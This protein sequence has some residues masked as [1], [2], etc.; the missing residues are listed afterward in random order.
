VPRGLKI[1]GKAMSTTLT[2]PQNTT[3]A[4]ERRLRARVLSGSAIM[5]VGSVFVGGMNLIY[6]FA[7]AHKLG[8]SQFGHAS[9]TYTIL[10][11]LSAVT[12][13]FQ[14]VC[15]K[16]VARSNSKIEQTAIYRHLH[17]RSWMYSASIGLCLT[18]LSPEIS[19]YLNLPT[20]LFV[21]IIAI[22]IVFYI[23]LGVR[24]GL[25]QGQCDFQALAVNLS[26]EVL[27]KLVG[28]VVLMSAGYGV[29]GVVGAMSASLIVA[30]FVAAPRKHHI[31]IDP[32]AKPILKTSLD[33]GIQA[34]IFFVGQVIIN[35]LD[36]LL[37]KHFFSATEAGTYAA[38]ALLGRLVY[39]LSWSVVSS[40][41]PL[42][43]RARSDEA[44]GRAVL[45]TALSLVLL[46]AV[47]FT[48]GA[49]LAP[50]SLWHVLLG[51]GFPA[52]GRGF[53]SSLLVLY[54]VTTAVYS[55]AVVL[56]TYEISRKIGNVSWLQLIFSGAIISGIYLFH[57]TLPQVIVVQLILMMFLLLIVAVPFARAGALNETPGEQTGLKR[58][59][60]IGEDEVIA[61][62]LRGEFLQHHEF[63]GYR[64]P[65]AK[66]V[67]Q[68]DLKNAQ[69]N[70]YRRALLDRRRGRLWRE[71]P[72]DTEWWEVE[73]SPQDIR[74]TRV[75][76]RNQWLRY[77]GRGF[78]L[79]DVAA[80]IRSHMLTNSQ[81]RFITK[82]KSLSIEVSE[83]VQFPSVI[84][85]AID[86]D[87][88]LT[89]IEGNHR[90]AAAALVSPE[91]A[92]K[93]F[94]F[95]C[96]FSSRMEE[97]CWYQTNPSTL[98]RYARNGFSYHFKHRKMMEAILKQVKIAP[99]A[100]K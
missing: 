74:R 29:A 11:L 47:V 49:W 8:A 77:G 1:S 6:N 27:I 30:Y 18:L 57:R 80:R 22:G 60:K 19:R 51:A 53:Y 48:L 79:L 65:F 32:T 40:M 16:F 50:T 59:R 26:L 82:L 31:S 97:C 91:T 95:F 3:H 75:F 5:L 2:N 13:S 96:G 10:M 44:G 70:D 67:A 20:N 34:L 37:V 43:A 78:W 84:L 81:D 93:R 41:F 45:S 76:A 71:L 4:A 99:I 23:P 7:I 92:H 94:R 21:R 25:L 56:M 52:V 66:L 63:L 42:S 36:I 98:F 89:I 28:A 39:I 85:I 38:V 83:N 90:M 24:R 12:L 9:V 58:I 72:N 14:L 88:A 100:P 73:L 64:E 86:D 62:F 33:E 17:R 54:I 68:P 46:I 87:S 15:S 61:E 35:N 55:L 69:E